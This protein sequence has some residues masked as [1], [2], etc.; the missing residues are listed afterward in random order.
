M[1]KLSLIAVMAAACIDLAA[2]TYATAVPITYDLV[3]V[4]ATFNGFGT[5]TLTGTFTFD[6]TKPVF[7]LIAVNITATEGSNSVLFSVPLQSTALQ[8]H[9][10]SNSDFVLFLKFSSILSGDAPDPVSS[11]EFEPPLIA[12]DSVTGFAVPQ[13][14]PTALP[15][16]ATGLGALG[17]LGWRRKRQN[18]ARL[19]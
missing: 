12:A 15:L 19:S 4:T 16:F 10:F 8:I 5:E 11:I 1:K 2:P 14:L 6:N 17:L 18:Q 7:G 9:A 3:G 13:P